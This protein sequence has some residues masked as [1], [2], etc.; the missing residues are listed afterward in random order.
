MRQRPCP[1][2]NLSALQIRGTSTC[3]SLVKCHARH[4]RLVKGRALARPGERSE[5]F[6]P[7]VI[8][9]AVWVPLQVLYKN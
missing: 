8:Q 1:F 5:R 9:V 6:E 7:I 3:T 2:A 4:T